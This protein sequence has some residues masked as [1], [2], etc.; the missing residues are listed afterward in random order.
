MKKKTPPPPKSTD[1][2][3]QSEF[4]LNIPTKPSM[5]TS[6]GKP[7]M[8]GISFGTGSAIGRHLVD[9]IMS[10]KPIEQRNVEMDWCKRL[11]NSYEKCAIDNI[12][13]DDCE[14]LQKVIIEYNCN[15][16]SRRQS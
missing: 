12:N 8:E 10:P 6:V 7:L 2:R 16:V 11:L 14:N 3:S 5:G 4:P 1:R 13:T 15:S 9:S